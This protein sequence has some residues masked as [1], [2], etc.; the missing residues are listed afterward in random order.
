[1][2]EKPSLH[3]YMMNIN[4]YEQCRISTAVRSS[5]FSVRVSREPGCTSKTTGLSRHRLHRRAHTPRGGHRQGH[6]HTWTGSVQDSR[7]LIKWN[8]T[9]NWFLPPTQTTSSCSDWWLI[10]MKSLVT[11]WDATIPLW[12]VNNRQYDESLINQILKIAVI[13]KLL[14]Y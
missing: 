5:S 4:M 3:I 9:F 1:M 8:R 13:G 10:M 14:W 12:K 11:R 6:M 2:S 7:C